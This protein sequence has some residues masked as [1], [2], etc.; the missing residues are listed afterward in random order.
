MKKNYRKWK[1]SKLLII[2]VLVLLLLLII[3]VIFGRKV[4]NH[5]KKDSGV[6][7]QNIDTSDFYHPLVPVASAPSST[8]PTPAV[9]LPI[10]AL[11]TIDFTSQAPFAVWDTLHEDTC[12]EAS[13][14]MVKHYLDKTPLGSA[15]E[16]DAELRLMV[17]WE[18]ANGYGPSISLEELNQIA[19][20]HYNLTGQIKTATVENIE[21]DI[22][23]GRPVIVP[24]GGKLLG[25]PNFTAGGPNYHMLVV[26]SYD[27]AHFITNDPGTRNGNSYVYSQPVL[28]NAIHNWDP[29]NIS[30]GSK[31]YI[32]F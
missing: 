28:M 22:A 13:F 4:Y 31:V 12:E 3:T 15:A 20:D 32:V 6:A 27:S 16:V 7:D 29:N 23:A 5:F 25:N 1:K 8:A 30:D 17:D 14:L 10:N 2:F 9:P 21:T 19:K 26:K 11:I 18:T 24:A